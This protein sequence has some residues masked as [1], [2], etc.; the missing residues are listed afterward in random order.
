MPR[1]VYVNGDYVPEEEAKISIFDRAFLFADGI[2]EVTAVIDGKLV[3]YA[4]HMERLHRSL[5]ELDMAQPVPDADILAMH[6]ELMARNKLTEGLIYMQITRG[7]AERD[8]AYPEDAE[9]TMIAFTME[10]EL[11]DP[12]AARTGI[13]IITIPDIRWQRRDIKSTGMLAQAMGKEAAKRAGAGDAW[14]VEDGYVTEGTSNTAFIVVDGNRLVTRP[15]S[16]S[17]LPGVT[18]RAILKLAEAGEITVEERPFTVEDAKNADEAFLTSAST[19]VMPV[20]EIDGVK[21]GGGQPGPI[22]RKLRELYI[23]EAR[24]G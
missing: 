10:K 8:F 6:E 22:T 14:M 1:I 16:H 7:V 3:D 20:I 23:S 9:Q 11:K 12:A 5:K 17:I 2:Y 24:K 4:P 21:V 19:I 18:R 15:L 13:S